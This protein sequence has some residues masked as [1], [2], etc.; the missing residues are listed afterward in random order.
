MVTMPALVTLVSLGTWQLQRLQWKNDLINKFEARI[1]APAVSPP[2]S[3]SVTPENEFTRLSLVGEF[4]HDQE[5]YLTGRTYEGNAGFHVVT[6]FL[7]ADG[8]TIL[9]N[10]GWVAESYRD[11]STREF[12]LVT[13]QVTVDTI[14]RMPAKKGYFVPEN[15]PYAGFW[16]TLVPS[17]IVDYLAVPAPVITGYYV[18]ALR[19][20]EVM[21][22]P[23]GAKTELN[24]RNVHLSYAMTW[25]GI[26]LAL[27]GV[28]GAFHYQAG[29]LRFGG[30]AK[31]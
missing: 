24:L 12:S 26:A 20:S 1:A 15:D 31:G 18:D 3:D 30:K 11:R 28:Y 25:Y 7:L 23:I 10:R 17:Q 9:I 27:L 2:Y 13:G 4:R 21:T 6:P 22:L 14:L 29:R 8:R 19:T 16:F 5:I